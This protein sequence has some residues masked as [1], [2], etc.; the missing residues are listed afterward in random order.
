M[1]EIKLKIR[2]AKRENAI[3]IDLS[4]MGLL[5]IPGDIMQLT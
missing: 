1:S 3:S 5:E 2:H 4:G